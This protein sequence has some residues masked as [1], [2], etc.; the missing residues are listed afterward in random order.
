M[1]VIISA[2]DARNLLVATFA[3]STDKESSA[4][5]WQEELF[6]I[7]RVTQLALHSPCRKRRWLLNHS[8]MEDTMH[9]HTHTDFKFALGSL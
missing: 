2:A 5:V 8:D 4:I 6:V 7:N 9:T 3:A 1:A